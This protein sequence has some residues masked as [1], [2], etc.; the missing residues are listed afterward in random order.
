MLEDAV[1]GFGSLGEGE[2][3]A[4]CS[5]ALTCVFSHLYLRDARFD[6]SS[7]LGPVDSESED[8]AA[9][10]VK[11]SMDAKLGKFLVVGPPTGAEGMGGAPDDGAPLAGDGGTRSEEAAW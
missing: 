7:F 8:A 9:A 6:F 3:R 1:D 11:G 5:S 4:R 2:A 10:A